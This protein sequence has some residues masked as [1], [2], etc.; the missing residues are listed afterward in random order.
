MSKDNIDVNSLKTA[1]HLVKDE[2]GNLDSEKEAMFIA[3]YSWKDATIFSTIEFMHKT[4]SAKSENNKEETDDFMAEIKAKSEEAKVAARREYSEKHASDWRQI[5]GWLVSVF[6]NGYMSI[7]STDE[8]TPS[9]EDFNSNEAF[10]HIQYIKC[11]ELDLSDISC[12]ITDIG[13]LELI[14]GNLR[15][16]KDQKIAGLDRVKVIGQT[17]VE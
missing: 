5:D 12:K 10:E 2:D 16:R 13:A 7:I 8:I 15:Y 4:Y 1:I 6:E 14:Y 17:I 3:S 11:P 9:D